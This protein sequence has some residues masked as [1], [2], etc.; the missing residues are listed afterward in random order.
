M[1]SPASFVH[2]PGACPELIEYPPGAVMSKGGY[3]CNRVVDRLGRCRRHA[4][5]E[6]KR[7]ARWGRAPAPLFQP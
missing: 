3:Y 1:P 4:T 7:A 6:E 5:A 2:I